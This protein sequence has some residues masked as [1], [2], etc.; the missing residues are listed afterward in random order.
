[1]LWSASKANWLDGRS[2]R[3]IT[4]N[5]INFD[6]GVLHNKYLRSSIDFKWISA[7]EIF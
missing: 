2:H 4:E 3:I 6:T 1:M 5:M 7:Q